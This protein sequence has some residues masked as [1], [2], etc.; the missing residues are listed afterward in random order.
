MSTARSVTATDDDV[1]CTY[2]TDMP[3]NTINQPQDL[4]LD[5]IAETKNRRKVNSRYYI[6][7]PKINRKVKVTSFISSIMYTIRV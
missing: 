6:L 7:W 3:A 4:G 1:T 5:E 2:R